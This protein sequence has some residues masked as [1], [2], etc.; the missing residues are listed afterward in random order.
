MDSESSNNQFESL[1]KRIKIFR[2]LQSYWGITSF[3]EKELP[4]LYVI[5]Y[6]ILKKVHQA[7]CKNKDSDVSRFLRSLMMEIKDLKTRMGH[8]ESA[9]KYEL[10]DRSVYNIVKMA[11]EKYNNHQYSKELI[12]E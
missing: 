9:Q 3:F 10:L 5:K 4:I 1:K 6:Y 7:T 11:D 2:D 8:M 12:Q